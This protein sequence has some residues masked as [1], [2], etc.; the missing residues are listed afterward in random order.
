MADVHKIMK[1]LSDHVTAMLV[2]HGPESVEYRM[3]H[4]AWSSYS[5]LVRAQAWKQCGGNLNSVSP[6]AAGRR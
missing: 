1:E 5:G 4:F 6:A 3:A 2:K